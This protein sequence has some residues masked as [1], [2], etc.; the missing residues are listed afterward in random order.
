LRC[1]TRP[2]EPGRDDSHEENADVPYYES[3]FIARP[4]ISASQVEALADGF[5]AIVDENGGSVTKNEYWGL[6]SLAYRI[7]KNRKGHYGLMNLDAPAAAVAELERN[8]RLNEDVLRYMTIRVDELEEEPSIVMRS[9][10]SRDDRGRR[11]DRGDRGDRGRRDD[12]GRQSEASASND[13]GR[14]AEASASNDGKKAEAGSD[15]AASG[16]DKE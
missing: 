9:K 7:K 5:K 15:G 6:K 16:G 2:V 11:D 4:D 8:M 12:R 13:R 10:G 1:W 14:Q 3:V